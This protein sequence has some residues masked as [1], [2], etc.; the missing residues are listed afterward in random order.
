M[1]LFQSAPM[2]TWINIAP[3]MRARWWNAG[4]ILGA[5]SI[6]LEI[7]ADDARQTLMFSGTI[8]DPNF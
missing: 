2:K 8:N 3:G 7:G 6:E 4:H 1:K 5:A